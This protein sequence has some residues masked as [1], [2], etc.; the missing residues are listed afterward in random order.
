MYGC[1]IHTLLGTLKTARL[2]TSMAPI[3]SPPSASNAIRCG[4]LLSNII[5]YYKPHLRLNQI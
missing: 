3:A 4:T 5:Q 1:L 2:A